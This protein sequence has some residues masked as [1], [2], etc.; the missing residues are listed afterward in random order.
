MFIEFLDDVQIR[1]CNRYSNL[2]LPET[3]TLFLEFHGTEAGAVDHAKQVGELVKQVGELVQPV[4]ELVQQVGE[5]C[6][7]SL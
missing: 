7:A 6:Q 5:L 4:G 1:A 3:P 2:T